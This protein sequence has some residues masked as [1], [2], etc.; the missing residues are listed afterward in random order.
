[1]QSVKPL[2]LLLLTCSLLSC[3]PTNPA[4]TR[5]GDEKTSDC[6]EIPVGVTID[7]REFDLAGA[8]MAGFSLGKFEVKDTPQF[9][10]IV[11]EAAS[12][13]AA[14]DVL[15]CKAIAR[16]GVRGNPEMVDYFTRMTHF[17]AKQPSISEQLQWRQTNPF[18]KVA[19]QGTTGSGPTPE[20]PLAIRLAK[21]CKQPVVGLNRRPQAFLPIWIEVVLRLRDAKFEPD[22]TLQNLYNIKS[23]IRDPGYSAPDDFFRESLYTL[24]CLEDVAEVKLVNLGTPEKYEGKVFENQR[25]VFRPP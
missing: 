23:R 16:A 24:R 4:T 1:M 19:A 8:T 21:V 14:T 12:N 25:I 18:P 11:S 9:Q 2:L 15:V 5:M 10:K 3:A 13:S 17:F 6:G 7:K 22:R 20:E